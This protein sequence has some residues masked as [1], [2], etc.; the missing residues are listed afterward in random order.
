MNRGYNN[1]TGN[2]FASNSFPTQ[3]P[4]PYMNYY[5]NN[6]HQMPPP[7]PLQRRQQRGGNYRLNPYNQPPQGPMMSYG[8]TLMKLRLKRKKVFSLSYS[9]IQISDNPLQQHN[10]F[11]PYLL[12][13]QEVQELLQP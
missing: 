6:T 13:A 2:R 9:E 11:F 4:T 3:Q 8:Q 1:L 10:L 7:R 12:T 5:P